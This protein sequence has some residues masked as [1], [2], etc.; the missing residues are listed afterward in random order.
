M[1]ISS[2]IEEVFLLFSF[3]LQISQKQEYFYSNFRFSIAAA[4]TE[5]IDSAFVAMSNTESTSIFDKKEY[6]M[7]VYN[8]RNEAYGKNSNISKGVFTLSFD[9]FYNKLTTSSKYVDKI[10]NALMAA[11][12]PNGVSNDDAF[13]SDITSFK[14]SVLLSK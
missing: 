13:T 10:Y 3:F 6:I 12:G 1:K 7:N 14:D 9:I 8:L 11:Y 4:A 2:N 5:A